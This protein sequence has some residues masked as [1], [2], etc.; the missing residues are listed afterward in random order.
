MLK[1][2]YRILYEKGVYMKTR[3]ITFIGLSAIIFIVLPFIACNKEN[4]IESLN[5]QILLLQEENDI[6]HTENANLKEE[7]DNLK[8]EIANLENEFGIYRNTDEY[9]YQLGADA[10]INKNYREAIHFMNALKIKFPASSFLEYADSVIIE[11]ENIIASFPPPR[12]IAG[13]ILRQIYGI[14]SE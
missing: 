8:L 12:N 14:Q 13:E 5:S 1:T 11:A 10:F 3:I 2:T 9:Y 7:I 6:I 4:T